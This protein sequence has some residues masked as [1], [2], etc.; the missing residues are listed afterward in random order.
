[1]AG[2]ARDRAYDVVVLGGGVNGAGVA[3]DCAMRGL[4]VLLLEKQDLA[5][6]ASGASSG[7]IH[8]GIRY[9]TSDR[10][11][12][13]LASRDAGYIRRIA[14]HLTFRIPFLLPF[15]THEEGSRLLDRVSLVRHRGL[16]R[17][18][19]PLPAA[20]GREA[21]GAPLRRRALPDRA[22]AAP[23]A[24]RRGDPRRVGD[25]R[26]AA[27]PAERAL[28]RRPRRRRAHL[29]RGHEPGPRGG[30]GGGGALPR[31]RHR[32]ARRGPRRGGG[33][34]HRGLVAPL[35]PVERVPGPHAPGQGGPPL[36]RPA[37]RELR[38]H[39][40]RRR[41]AADVPHAARDGV[42]HRDHRRRL[43]R[44]PRRPRRHRRR[45]R[46]PGRRRRV[47]GAVDPAGAH[48]PGLVGR[49]HHALRVRRGGGRPLPRPPD[50]RPRRRGFGR[51][52][53]LR[54]RQAGELPGPVGGARRPGRGHARQGG[55]ALPHPRGA[56]AGRRR[57]PFPGASWP[58]GTASP[59][60]SRRA[61]STGTGRWRARCSGSPTTTRA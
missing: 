27:L 15:A 25:R 51:A 48:H 46:V 45:G 35:R 34:R 38:D 10:R 11:V 56:A 32:R 49:P 43:L 47:A 23:R 36:P 26:A 30:P 39:L 37:P 53:L 44:R 40:H 3:R 4:S 13:A 57:G 55:P 20:Q 18:L 12:T 5:C 42:D 54:R 29:D 21:V 41:R 24:A 59:S 7:M 16:R 19:R 28:G 1:M 22:L 8:G 2:P 9:M 33:E 60:R 52:A 14:P 61:S 17:H 58:P 31:R 6:G 50:P